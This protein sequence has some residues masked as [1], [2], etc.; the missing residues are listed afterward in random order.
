MTIKLFVRKT[1]K[2]QTL[3]LL[4]FVSAVPLCAE[5][6]NNQE[7]AQLA[8]IPSPA[9]PRGQADTSLTLLAKLTDLTGTGL[10]YGLVPI[11]GTTVGQWNL[12]T[13][14]SLAAL[15]A[16]W[17]KTTETALG[18]ALYISTSSP[19]MQE[20]EESTKNYLLRITAN[21]A[22]HVTNQLIK[23]AT[24]IVPFY[25]LYRQIPRLTVPKIRQIIE[26]KELLEHAG[27][28]VS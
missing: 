21:G 25:L 26:A 3:A 16:I 13:T 18:G 22:I 15:N 20:A 28:K 12:E 2:K 19:P 6:P 4:L 23:I 27:F 24:G 1:M 11:V 8:P 14:L 10:Q 9:Q 17:A 7:A 5:K